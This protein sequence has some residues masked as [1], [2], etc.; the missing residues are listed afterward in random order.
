MGLIMW[1]A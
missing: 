1:R